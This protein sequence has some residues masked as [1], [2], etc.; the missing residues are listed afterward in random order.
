KDEFEQVETAANVAQSDY[1]A[2]LDAV[3]E[4]RASRQ[5]ALDNLNKTIF[6]AP[7]DGIVSQLNVEAGENVITGTMNNP[8]TQI[9][10]VADPSSMLV[11]AAVD[12]TDI[13]NVRIGQPAKIKVDAFPDSVF[14][15][16]VIEVG[17]TAKLN[18]SL[19]G[20]TQDQSNFEVKVV[21]VDHV[22]A[23]RPG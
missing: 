22:P 20:G 2:A 16:E 3:R 18:N 1:Q 4:T 21:F 19:T 13:V 5:A 6:S 12:E 10:A 14:R 17:N 11:R 23:M 9:L 15:G 7:F 8:G